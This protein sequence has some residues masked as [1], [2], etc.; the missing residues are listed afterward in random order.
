M[1][2]TVYLTSEEA[3]DYLRLKLRKLY[4]LVAEGAVPC[5]KVTGK[6]LFPRDELDRWVDSGLVIPEGMSTTRPPPVVGGAHD[7]LLE[8]ALRQSGSGL[9]M[10]IESSEIGLDRLVRDEVMIAAVHLQRDFAD[11]R[12]NVEAVEARPGLH[13]AVI[14]AFAVRTQGLMVARGNPKGLGGL[15]DVLDRKARIGMRAEGTGAQLLLDR[16]LERE[17]IDAAHLAAANE[18]FASAQDIAIAIR[19]DEI[20]CGIATESSARVNG[21]DF[22]P[23]TDESFDLV[24]RRRNYFEP[25]PQRLMAYVRGSQFTRAANE[26]GGYDIAHAGLVRLNK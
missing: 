16:L 21:L 2:P 23:L 4:E 22:V 5:S 20:D 7:L 11:D 13:D 3:A 14:I 12:T 8:R 19:M 9:A 26:F 17:R 6:W 10:L 24:M 18:K 15:A 25:G 1:E